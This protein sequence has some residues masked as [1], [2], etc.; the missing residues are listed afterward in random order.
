MD[1]GILLIEFEEYYIALFATVFYS[2]CT[3]A[4]IRVTTFCTFCF[5]CHEMFYQHSCLAPSLLEGDNNV[6]YLT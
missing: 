2:I 4:P 1:T 3:V 6:E 5:C